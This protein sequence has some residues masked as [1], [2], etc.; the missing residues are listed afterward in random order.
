MCSEPDTADRRLDEINTR[1]SLFGAVRSSQES[2]AAAARGAL[3]LRYNRAIRDYLGAL[4]RD[5]SL[6][7]E[8]AQEVVVKLLSG[9]FD[10][11]DPRR[12]RFRDLLKV[13]VKNAVRSRWTSDAR[14]RTE[15]L[16]KDET[17]LTS[18]DEVSSDAWESAWREN[19]L[20]NAW[21]ALEEFQQSHPGSIAYSVLRARAAEPDADMES[22]AKRILDETG[23]DLRADALR[24]QLRRARLRFA[25]LLV[26]EIAAALSDPSP[27]RV[28][29]ELIAVGLHAY[30][31]DYVG[32]SW[33]SDGALVASP[34]P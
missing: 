29:D 25:Q 17:A 13:S 24:Q 8:I 21:K 5:D 27:Q 12:G 18:N 20:Q 10:G 30:I 9:R 6:A 19:L 11:A 7:D 22:L 15:P 34:F 31:K 14:R 32:E 2:D 4:V 28:E 26:E 3:A 1:W 16:L 23:R 33:R